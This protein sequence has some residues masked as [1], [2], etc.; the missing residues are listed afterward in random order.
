M[1]RIKFTCL[2][3]NHKQLLAPEWG[4]LS[5]RND[6]SDT[7]GRQIIVVYRLGGEIAHTPVTTTIA[8]TP[9]TVTISSVICTIYYTKYHH[10]SHSRTAVCTENR[11]PRPWT[12]APRVFYPFIFLFLLSSFLFLSSPLLKLFIHSFL[13]SLSSLTILSSFNLYCFLYVWR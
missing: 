2:E 12:L 11:T 7:A 6:S 1:S 13:F 10:Q 9:T 3:I 8:A 4:V 5:A